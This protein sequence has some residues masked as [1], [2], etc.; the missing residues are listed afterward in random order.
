MGGYEGVVCAGASENT[1]CEF[2][3]Q[4]KG[5]VAALSNLVGHISIVGRGYNNGDTIV[6]FRRATQH[7][8]PTDIDI[9][10]GFFKCDVRPGNRLLKGIEI[11]DYQINGTD[12]VF[13]GRLL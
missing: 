13:V 7:R 3:T 5:S 4:L 8:R 2:A 1:G 6:I 12:A 11:D 9:F 10:D